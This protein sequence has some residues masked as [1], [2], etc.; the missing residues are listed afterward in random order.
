MIR[1][2]MSFG[3]E[4]KRTGR[5]PTSNACSAIRAA[6]VA[7]RTDANVATAKTSVPPAVARD[8][9]VAQSATAA[10]A[11]HDPSGRCQPTG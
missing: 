2:E 7:E 8:E 9:I 1:W 5:T 4:G 10:H 11:T 3:R 6:R